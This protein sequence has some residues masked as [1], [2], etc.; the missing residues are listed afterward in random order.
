MAYPSIVFP[1]I[2]NLIPCAL[3]PEL[4]EPTEDWTIEELMQWCLEKSHEATDEKVEEFVTLNRKQLEQ[5]KEELW[6]CFNET[7]KPATSDI[8]AIDSVESIH[9]KA[10][11]GPYIDQEFV[12]KPT[13]RNPCFIGRSTSKKFRDRGMSLKKDTEVS[14]THGKIEIIQGKVFFTDLGSTNGSHIGD[15]MLEPNIPHQLEEGMSL[16]LGSG[17]FLI[18]LG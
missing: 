16:M 9:L 17:N 13:A 10:L 12:V 8:S 15:T 2:Y 5:A 18:H 6:N 3:S 11:S 14:T 7:Q 1:R 4:P